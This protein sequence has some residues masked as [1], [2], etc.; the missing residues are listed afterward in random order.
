MKVGNNFCVGD[1]VMTEVILVLIQE[2]TI[3]IRC[4]RFNSQKLINQSQ[5]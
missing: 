3:P 5:L 1:M 4:G 2:F